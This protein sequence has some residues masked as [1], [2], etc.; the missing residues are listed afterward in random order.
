MGGRRRE[1]PSDTELV[2]R[3]LKGDE[4]GWELLLA[5]YRRM[6][7]NI[8][9]QFVGR[10]EEAEDLVQEIFLKLMSSLK[11][12]D[13]GSNLPQWLSRVARNYCIDYYRRKR[14]EKEWMVKKGELMLRFA[15]S[16]PSQFSSFER[17]EQILMLKK[18]IAELPEP[19]R[20]CLTLR[21]FE[22]YSYQEIAEELNIPLGTVKSRINRGRLELLKLF[23]R[24]EGG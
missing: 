1:Q 20:I 16:S 4:G 22:G 19:I 2:E 24:E 21:E 15:P 12:F 5:R 13:L 7:F 14:K 9:Y 11:K 23:E 10:V 3:C 17:R 6:V 8:A 18:A